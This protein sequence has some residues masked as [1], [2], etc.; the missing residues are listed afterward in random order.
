MCHISEVPLFFFFITVILYAEDP[1]EL[2]H[3]YYIYD[4]HHKYNIMKKDL[5]LTT[6]LNLNA[7][8]QV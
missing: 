5:C 8:S 7:K 2:S 6:L 1:A 3:F 4:V